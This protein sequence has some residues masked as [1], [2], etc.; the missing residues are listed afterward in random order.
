MA[1]ILTSLDIVNQSFGRGLGGYNRE[2]V[3]SFLDTVA[4]TLQYYAEYK[5]ES[6]EALSE[7]SERLLEYEKMKEDLHEALVSA[8]KTAKQKVLD[9]DE[10][11]AK[12]IG[13]AEIHAD[14]MCREAASKADKL[15][16]GVLQ[17]K[18][19]KH[20]FEDE[21]RAN[22]MKYDAM[23]TQL[24]QMDPQLREAVDSVLET[25]V[26]ETT[27]EAEIDTLNEDKDLSEAYAM[28]GV[29]P[30]DMEIDA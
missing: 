25:Y 2:E 22:L 10:K 21:F 29:A 16:E 30:E 27:K 8:Q 12:I 7:M 14:Q 17:I 26:P 9:A 5:Q 20:M 3:D 13:D 15:R 4:E 19:I 11:A 1:E 24:S 6:E 18:K 23:L 28:L